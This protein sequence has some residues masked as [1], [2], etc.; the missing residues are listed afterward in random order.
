MYSMCKKKN[1]TA[2]PVATSKSSG[3]SVVFVK[4]ISSNCEVLER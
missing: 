1:R 3:T 4:Y 2:V